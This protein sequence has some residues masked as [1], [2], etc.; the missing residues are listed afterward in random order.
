MAEYI[1]RNIHLLQEKL[2]QEKTPIY[3][4]GSAKSKLYQILR[5]AYDRFLYPV[6]NSYLAD[7]LS[8]FVSHSESVLD[9]GCAEGTIPYLIS[10]KKNVTVHGVDIYFKSEPLIPYT[11]YNGT[12]LPFKD[13]QFDCSIAVDA[14]H[15]CENIKR[16]L[17]EMIRVSHRIIIKDHYYKNG[18]DHFLLKLFDISANKPYG[19][20]IIFNFKKWEEWKQIFR[21]LNLEYSYVDKTMDRIKLGPL[22]HFCILLEENNKG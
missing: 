5:N 1:D 22:K 20:N 2:W 7:Y 10:Q 11:R 3:L 9:I 13:K 15:H 17:Q 8:K 18:W 16:T 21:E 14:L 4:K 6:R 12:T 19:V